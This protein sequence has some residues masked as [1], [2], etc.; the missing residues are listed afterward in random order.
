MI[1]RKELIEEEEIKNQL[2]P[3]H[4]ILMEIP[5]QTM[6]TMRTME[7]MTEDERAAGRHVLLD[8]HLF[9]E[10]LLRKLEQS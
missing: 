6:M 4:V 9:S 10:I 7:R 3:H 8:G 1:K 2:G 5:I